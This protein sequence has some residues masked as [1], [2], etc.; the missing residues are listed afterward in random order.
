MWQKASHEN[1]AKNKVASSVLQIQ[2][3]NDANLHL[4]FF[5]SNSRFHYMRV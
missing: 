2:I 5:F 3:F 1:I 4:Q